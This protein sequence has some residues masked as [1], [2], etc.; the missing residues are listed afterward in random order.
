LAPA[1]ELGRLPTDA[2]LQ[3]LRR[4]F[5]KAMARMRAMRYRKED[6]SCTEV[7]GGVVR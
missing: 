7:K 2:E 3:L 6:C 5:V 1:K 4:L